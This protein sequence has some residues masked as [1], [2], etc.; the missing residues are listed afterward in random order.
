MP[1][2]VLDDQQAQLSTLTGIDI[3]VFVL[4]AQEAQLSTS[5]G[6]TAA[7]FALDAQEAQL[8]TL[9]GAIVLDLVAHYIIARSPT[10]Q[11]RFV[12]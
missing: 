8:N 9:I 5:T 10:M 11:S 12:D 4:D 1:V 6:S 2:S 3:N 7:E